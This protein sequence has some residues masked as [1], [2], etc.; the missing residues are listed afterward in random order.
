MNRVPVTFRLSP[1]NREG[2]ERIAREHG[3]SFSDVMRRAIHEALER[4]E[5]HQSNRE[6]LLQQ[7]R[8]LSHEEL[9]S[10]LRELGIVPHDIQ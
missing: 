5:T 10:I 7:L 9:L 6:K 3:C 1:E 4:R 2:I 8:S